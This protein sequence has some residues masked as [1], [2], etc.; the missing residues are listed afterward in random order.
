MNF[1]FH[2]VTKTKIPDFSRMHASFQN[3]LEANRQNKRNTVIK[4]FN[5]QQPRFKKNANNF[6]DNENF[7]NFKKLWSKENRNNFEDKKVV[8]FWLFLHHFITCT[9]NTSKN[10]I[11]FGNMLRYIFPIFSTVIP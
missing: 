10:S 2:P 4:P 9:F 6:V 8:N 7:N 5:F 1:T 3:L 11:I